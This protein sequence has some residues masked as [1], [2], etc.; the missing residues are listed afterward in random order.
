MMACGQTVRQQ[1]VSSGLSAN[2]RMLRI[3]LLLEEVH[4]LADAIGVSFRLPELHSGVTE[5]YPIREVCA[6]DALT[7]ITYVLLGTYHT[8][9]LGALAVPAFDE[10]HSSNM[11][12]IDQDGTVHRRDDGKI[13][14][15]DTYRPADLKKVLTTPVGV[16]PF[17]AA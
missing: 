9:G 16:N 12:K 3:R 7:D 17:S 14:K 15:P 10:V 8:L 11:S 2:E 6:L 5:E 4:E 1:P 13:L